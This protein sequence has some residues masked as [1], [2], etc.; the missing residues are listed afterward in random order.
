MSLCTFPSITRRVDVP[1]TQFASPLCLVFESD[2]PLNNTLRGPDGKA[3]YTVS[4]WAGTPNLTVICGRRDA[5]TN[6]TGTGS[7]YECDRRIAEIEKRKWKRDRVSFGSG[8]ATDIVKLFE[9]G[10]ISAGSDEIECVNWHSLSG[11]FR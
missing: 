2:D 9:C 7:R 1:Q 10:I 5:D 11:F 3:W 6:G 8:G 4:T